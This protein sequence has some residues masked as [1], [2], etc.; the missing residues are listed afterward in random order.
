MLNFALDPV[1]HEEASRMIADKPAVVRDMFDKM[2]DEMKAR[3]FTISGVENMDVLQN[4][5]DLISAVPLG[6]DWKEARTEIARQISPWF[7]EAGADSRAQLLLDFHC[8]QATSA[9]QARIELAQSDIFTHRI[10]HTNHGPTV[11][12]SHAAL[13]G[14]ILPSTDPFWLTHWAHWTFNCHCFSSPLMEEEVAEEKTADESRAPERRRVLDTAQTTRLNQGT[15]TRGPNVNHLLDKSYQNVADAA[16]PYD[17]LA[18]RWDSPTRKDF[19][20]WAK[21]I[22]IGNDS[23]LSQLDGSTTTPNPVSGR[24][25]RPATFAEALRNLNIDTAATWSLTDLANLRSSMRVDDPAQASDLIASIGSA[26]KAGVLT[27]K[28]IHRSVQDLLDILPREIADTLPKLDIRFIQRFTKQAVKDSSI[29]GDYLGEKAG[30]PRIRISIDALK[31]LQGEAR[32][33]EMRRILS[34]ELMHWVHGESTGLPAER[35]RAAIRTH[36]A[37]RTGG[38]A[39]V[40]SNGVT[41][42]R[43]HWWTANA[44]TE[45]PFE[46]GK[47]GGIEL[48]S[49]YFELWKTPEKLME[50]SDMD[51]PNAAA[52]RQTFSLVHSIF[53]TA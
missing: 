41:L 50:L 10:Y 37:N 38:D 27:D 42:R 44:G 33:R 45:Y 32:R 39:L 53:A 49:Y 51:Q 18:T 14:I 28:E 1:P 15:I 21:K 17:E 9:T 5:R 52:F 2:P 43:D 35:Y 4:A 12:A 31:G 20:S 16:I 30:G 29:L 23:L 46:L 24:E 11:R 8:G 19:E 34:H 26:R 3:A 6:A 13:D 7:T 22:P 47:P 25:S 40:T 36:Y 48:P